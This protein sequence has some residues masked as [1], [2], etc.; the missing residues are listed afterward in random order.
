M[1][2]A[3][4]I[5]RGGKVS[6]RSR[7]TKRK[8][9]R[10]RK[11]RVPLGTGLPLTLNVKLKYFQSVVLDPTGGAQKASYVWRANS[12]YDPDYTGIGHQPMYHDEWARVYD[13]YDVIKSKCRVQAVNFD[14]ATASSSAASVQAKYQVT[15]RTTDS[16]SSPASFDVLQ[17]QTGTKYKLLHDDSS[18]GV[19]LKT[20]FN[21][22]KMWPANATDNNDADFGATPTKVA[23]FMLDAYNLYGS[24]TDPTSNPPSIVVQVEIVYTVKLSQRKVQQSHS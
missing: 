9:V 10:R 12:I 11:T 16:P 1:P 13:H 6:K 24:L 3:P 20:G 21:A 23:Y 8:I 15:L 17:E 4:R 18:A 22:K 7:R 14:S 19:W 5:R 2:R